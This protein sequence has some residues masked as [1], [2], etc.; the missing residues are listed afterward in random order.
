MS[1]LHLYWLNWYSQEVFV[2]QV[3]GNSR[4]DDRL[5]VWSI[6]TWRHREN[7][8]LRVLFNLLKHLCID[9]LRLQIQMLK[10]VE[11]GELWVLSDV[12]PLQEAV[13]LLSNL[14]WPFVDINLV[15]EWVVVSDLLI[16]FCIKVHSSVHI[17]QM[18]IS[19]QVFDKHLRDWIIG[20]VINSL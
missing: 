8:P 11:V 16:I 18:L 2:V 20:K 7:L 13:R 12:K 10:I 19:L 6:L 9:Y 15:I 3:E 14:S 4:N 5:E 1:F 17:Y